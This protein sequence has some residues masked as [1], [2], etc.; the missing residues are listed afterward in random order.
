VVI[1]G[2]VVCL[3]WASGLQAQ[4]FQNLDFEDA[5]LVPIPG[6]PYNRVDF[7]LAL[8]GWSGFSGTNQ[9]NAAL[10]DN[11]FLDSTGIGIMDSNFAFLGGVIQ[12]NY[13]V[14]LEAGDQL[15]GGT[16]PASASLSQTGL[17]PTGTKS[18]SFL[19]ATAGVFTVSLGGVT[20]NLVSSPVAG[21]SYS[22]FQADISA[23]AGQTN[24]LTF[25]LFPDDPRQNN[26]ALA[27]DDIQFS[28]TQVPEPSSLS[29]LVA[30]VLG[31]FFWQQIRRKIA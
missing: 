9:L 2:V 3:G 29:L 23:F 27:L 12:G 28:T 15:G 24:A 19:A 8:P 25:T 26:T 4:P 22:L 6:D 21:Q 31:L 30:G 16:V 11:I 17:V 20:L 5:T 14:F 13:T 1:L 10:Y 18:L 7:S